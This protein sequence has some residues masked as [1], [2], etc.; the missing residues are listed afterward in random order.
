MRKTLIIIVF[1]AV[2]VPLLFLVVTTLS[3]YKPEDVID[4]GSG[5]ETVAIPMDDTLTLVTWNI[6][7]AG[8]GREMDFFY[9]GGRQVRPPEI[10]YKKYWQGIQKKLEGFSGE[11]E[12]VLLQE[13]D[14]SS[15]RSYYNDQYEVIRSVYTGYH[16]NFA[17]NYRVI[18]VPVPLIR[19]LGKVR[20]G[21]ALISSFPP[22][23]SGRIAFEGNFSWPTSLF[24]PDRCFIKNRYSTSSGKELV[25]INTH[26]SAFDNGELRTKQMD[27]LHSV[28]L[29]EYEKGN[30]VI[31]GG[32]WNMNPEG[33][34]VYLCTTGDMQ[35]NIQPEIPPGFFPDGW[36]WA[37]DQ[38]IPTNRFL[39]ES[40]LR[41]RTLTTT[42]DYFVVSP[43]VEVLE[44]IAFDLNFEDSD[45]HPVTMQVRL[46]P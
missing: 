13:I 12:F 20:S 40:Y 25:V 23:S 9:E 21:M 29:D 37:F 35:F 43:N 7:Y 19:P 3:D 32:D 10:L 5:S 27:A 17:F 18:Y 41:S 8:L 22:E 4:L 38:E 31:T 2:F 44:T 28:M 24:M 11:Y 16:S 36:T 34:L 1:V 42:I 33:F 46:K 39:Q 6:G 30:Y 15:K 26:N 45:H 14:V